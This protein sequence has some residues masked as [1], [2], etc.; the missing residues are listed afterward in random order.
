MMGPLPEGPV[1]TRH[2]AVYV[3]HVPRLGYFKIGRSSSPTLRINQ[4]QSGC[5]E[6]IDILGASQ[7]DENGLSAVEFETALHQAL[8]PYRSHGEWFAHLTVDQIEFEWRRVWN[9]LFASH[10]SSAGGVGSRHAKATIVPDRVVGTAQ[11][12]TAS[13]VSVTE[14]SERARDV[15]GLIPPARKSAM[16]SD[17]RR[18]LAQAGVAPGPAEAKRKVGRPRSAKSLDAVKPWEAEGVSRRTWYYRRQAEKR[19]K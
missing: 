18:N 10:Q 7:I 14:Q 16:N 12:K 15:G 6:R 11:V 1:S 2:Q 19:G 4:L 8:Y 5:P 13:A 9:D 3:M 17:P